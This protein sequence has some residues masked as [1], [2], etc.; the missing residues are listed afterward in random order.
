MRVL[1]FLFL[2]FIY[3]KYECC[4]RRVWSWV[5]GFLQESYRLVV[6]FGCRLILA[7]FEV[8]KK[9]GCFQDRGFWVCYRFGFQEGRLYRQGLFFFVDQLVF[10]LFCFQG[11]F[12]FLVEVDQFFF[13]LVFEGDLSRGRS[14]YVRGVRFF[15]GQAQFLV[16][17][18]LL[19]VSYVGTGVGLF[20]SI[21]RG[22]DVVSR[23]SV[24]GG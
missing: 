6:F 3:L 10:V 23:M 7:R 9:R 16:Y 2:I 20:F 17:L 14:L 24:I 21:Y 19:E 4:V 13:R 18:L 1:W 11:F 12:W 15:L 22:G 5:T 8:S